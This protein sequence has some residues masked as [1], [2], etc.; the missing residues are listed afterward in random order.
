MQAARGHGFSVLLR[1]VAVDSVATNIRRVTARVVQ[2]GH[3]I[4]SATIARRVA[5]SLANLPA[6]IAIASEAILVDNTETEHVRVMEIRDGRIT[7]QAQDTPKWLA[8]RLPQILAALA[9]AERG[10]G[11]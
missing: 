8:P 11:G 1:Y 3:F 5:G 6:A 2:G 7:F 9:A 10:T 4:D